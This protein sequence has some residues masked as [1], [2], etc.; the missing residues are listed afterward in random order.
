[1]FH[2]IFF[3]FEASWSQHLAVGVVI[4]V[5]RRDNVQQLPGDI[6]LLEP[7]FEELRDLGRPEHFLDICKLSLSLVLSL[8]L[9]EFSPGREVAETEDSARF[10][11]P[12]H[13]GLDEVEVVGVPLVIGEGVG[14]VQNAVK[15]LPRQDLT[16]VLRQTM[17]RDDRGRLIF[18]PGNQRLEDLRVTFNNPV[19][20][21]PRSF[22]LR[23]RNG[24][25]KAELQH[26]PALTG[27]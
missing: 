7:T 3:I 6:L 18:G 19:F 25:T 21:H 8:H 17:E 20:R 26:S 22:Y 9:H 4:T 16:D 12:H 24:Q 5:L 10:E 27:G 15:I 2:S 1:M 13:V 14:V 23:G 11:Q